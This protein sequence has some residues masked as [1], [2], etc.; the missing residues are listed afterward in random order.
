[1]V[2]RWISTLAVL[3]KR[4]DIIIASSTF[5][6]SQWTSPTKSFQWVLDEAEK[7]GVKFKPRG[8]VP[9]F[10]KSAP[11]T[12]LEPEFEPTVVPE[13][14]DDSSGH[15]DEACSD[16]DEIQLVDVSSEPEDESETAEANGANYGDEGDDG[17]GAGVYIQMAD[18]SQIV[19]ENSNHPVEMAIST[20]PAAKPKQKKVQKPK[21]KVQKPRKRIRARG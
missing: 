18:P 19:I 15:T 5:G 11:I 17:E 9:E 3:R 12:W 10:P 13:I 6:D 14:E 7:F 21:K 2:A 4:D 20:K 1:M 16:D 8:E